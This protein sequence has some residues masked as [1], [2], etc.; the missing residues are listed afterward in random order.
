MVGA[1]TWRL[2]VS[3]QQEALS[4]A[5]HWGRS[6]GIMKQSTSPSPPG[7]WLH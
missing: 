5:S 2:E 7:F 4:G 6:E 1:M 3:L